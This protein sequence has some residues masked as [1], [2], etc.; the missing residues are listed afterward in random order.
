MHQ[1]C[2]LLLHSLHLGRS[3][4]VALYVRRRGPCEACASPSL[5]DDTL[6]FFS[7]TLAQIIL[8]LII[9]IVVASS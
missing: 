5:D 9:K 7:S 4:T 3:T 8:I 2:S 1:Q 6:L